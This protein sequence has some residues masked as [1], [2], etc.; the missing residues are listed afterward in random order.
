M[1]E[2]VNSKCLIYID[3]PY[4][5]TTKYST[6]FDHN[7][8]WEVVR[9]FSSKHDIYVSEYVAP[10]DFECVWSIIRKTE[11]N[12]KQGKAIRTERLFKGE[13]R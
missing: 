1:F 6:I 3:P 10:D 13:V 8:F 2:D 11:L 12:T 7:R 5:G 9:R 4:K